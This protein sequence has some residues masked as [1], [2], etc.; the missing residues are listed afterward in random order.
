M[1]CRDDFT[2]GR[3]AI[4][5]P[6][7]AE[8]VNS[9]LVLQRSRRR[10]RRLGDTGF[11][12]AECHNQS[13]DRRRTLTRNFQPLGLQ[14]GE[15][16]HQHR[17]RCHIPLF[18]DEE[19]SSLALPLTHNVQSTSMSACDLRDR[20][21]PTAVSRTCAS[22]SRK[23]PESNGTASATGCVT[24]RVQALRRMSFPTNGQ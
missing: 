17:L 14:R 22:V 1:F 8:S 2:Q 20:R 7:R 16:A 3:T 10:M 4:L 11:P 9:I 19:P 5:G 21:A 12:V 15:H 24:R 18:G 13:R 6:E 23:A